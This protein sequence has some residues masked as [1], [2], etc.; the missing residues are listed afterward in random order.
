MIR[1]PLPCL[2]VEHIIVWTKLLGS[3]SALEN[4]NQLQRLYLHN[5][6]ITDV[7]VLAGLKQLVDLRLEGNPNLNDAEIKKLQKALPKC[8]I[9][10]N[11]TK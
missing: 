11:A 3:P 6:Q 10:H 1:Q 4:L 7:R 5:N 9:R 8:R 2:I